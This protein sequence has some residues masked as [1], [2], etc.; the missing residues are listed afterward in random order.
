M[1]ER[2]HAILIVE[3]IP[4]CQKTW[5]RFHG[6]EKR[7]KFHVEREGEK[8]AGR[9]KRNRR[10]SVQDSVREKRKKNVIKGGGRRE[11]VKGVWKEM[12]VKA[13]IE[14]VKEIRKRNGKEK[15]MSLVR[16]EDRERK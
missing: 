9:K 1:W 10:R 14:E 12:D 7:E 6:I 8:F 4:R 13:K 5:K 15:K 11:R 2:F 16:L 3:K